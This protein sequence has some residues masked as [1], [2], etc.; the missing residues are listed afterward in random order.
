MAA[1][2]IIL[3]VLLRDDAR[4]WGDK[5]F[6]LGVILAGIIGGNTIRSTIK[7]RKSHK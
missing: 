5:V 2:F 7:K 4:C 1:L 3:V 6:E